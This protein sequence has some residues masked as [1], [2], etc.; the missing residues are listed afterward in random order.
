MVY[1]IHFEKCLKQ[2]KRWSIRQKLAYSL[3]GGCLISVTLCVPLSFRINSEYRELFKIL[4]DRL[5]DI[6]DSRNISIRF[7]KDIYGADG[8]AMFFSAS[9][10]PEVVKRLCVLAEESIPGARLLDVDVTNSKG[11]A[12]GREQ[13]GLPPRKCFVCSNPAHICVSRR[14]HSSK[15]IALTVKKL[16]EEAIE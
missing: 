2:G 9:S 13:L 3:N 6:F 7:E 1:E 5:K 4:C 16:F 11:E 8:P 12:I 14:L 10:S 15:D